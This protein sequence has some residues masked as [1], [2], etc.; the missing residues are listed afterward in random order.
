[1]PLLS[2]DPNRTPRMA[3]HAHSN[4]FSSK[5]L[6]GFPPSGYEISGPTPRPSVLPRFFGFTVS[7]PQPVPGTEDRCGSDPRSGPSAGAR[8]QSRSAPEPS[9][10]FPKSA[11]HDRRR[12]ATRRSA[13]SPPLGWGLQTDLQNSVAWPVP[14]LLRQWPRPRPR[15]RYKQCPSWNV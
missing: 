8:E 14:F 1:G 4:S 10:A 6:L 15:G 12:R 13:P 3:F 11:S 7:F 2:I 9:P 5:G